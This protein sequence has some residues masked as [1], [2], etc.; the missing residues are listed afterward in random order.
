MV[1]NE[2]DNVLSMEQGAAYVDSHI[3]PCMHG[4]ELGREVYWVPVRA[5]ST[6]QRTKSL[7]FAGYCT[8]KG[9]RTRSK[10]RG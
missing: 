10:V 9:C 8:C 7:R 5:T 3:Q 4:M 6:P 1:S 2:E